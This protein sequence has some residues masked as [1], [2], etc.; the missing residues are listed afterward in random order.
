[1]TSNSLLASDTLSRLSE[2]LSERL[3]LI[4]NQIQVLLK[5]PSYI[6]FKENI[7]EKIVE[8]QKSLSR[9]QTQFSRVPEEFFRSEVVINLKKR[10]EDAES[11]LAGFRK[12]IESKGNA[13]L[14]SRSSLQWGRKIFHTA[15]G[16][17]GL[18]LYAFS[19]LSTTTVIFILATLFS[20]SVA[21]EIVRRVWPQTN[22]KLCNTFSFIMRERERK[23][24]SSATW[25]MGSMLVVFLIFPKDVSILTLLFVA[26]GDTAA[27]IVGVK[28]GRHRLSSHVSL[29]GSLAAYVVCF[30][31]TFIFTKYVFVH[32]HLSTA[33]LWLFSFLGG[34]VGAISESTF[35]KFDDNLVIPM[36]SAPSLWLLMKLFRA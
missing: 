32:F 14:S 12:S 2:E 23:S 36:V 8:W 18:W 28:W 1:M 15:S 27:G 29:E 19:S 31:S 4:E 34:W 9:L 13:L 30:I 3:D 17:F 21:T 6:Q 10:L 24:I 7:G 11:V 5:T 35:K 25:Y 33:N 26:L 16:L 20:G 22:D